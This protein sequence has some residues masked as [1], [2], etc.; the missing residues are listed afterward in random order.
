MMGWRS[1]L[2]AARFSGSGGS[3][4]VRFAHPRPP[5]D[6]PV[7]EWDVVQDALVDWVGFQFFDGD[8]APRVDRSAQPAAAHA[9]ASLVFG[10]GDFDPVPLRIG[11]ESRDRPVVFPREKFIAQ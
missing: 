2:S 7:H 6:E 10:D 3:E 9:P 5:A 11:L 4:P 1:R 8:D